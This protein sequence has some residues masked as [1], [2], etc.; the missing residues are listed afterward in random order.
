[1]LRRTLRHHQ[2]YHVTMS[3]VIDEAM[4]RYACKRYAIYAMPRSAQLR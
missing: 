2:H 1:M 4:R 3:R